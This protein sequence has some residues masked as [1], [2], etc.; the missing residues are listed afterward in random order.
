MTNISKNIS[1]K[2]YEKNIFTKIINKEIPTEIIYENEE[3]IVF[4]DINPKA[5][6]HFLILPKKNY[7]DYVHFLFTA[8]N[9]EKKFMEETILYIVTNYNLSN[10]KIIINHGAEAGQEIFH[11]HIHLM[12]Y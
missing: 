1:I 2:T 5:K 11:F 8:S 9:E 12:S 4:H 7:I 3:I 6:L 10:S